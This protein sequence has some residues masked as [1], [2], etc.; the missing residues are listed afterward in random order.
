[1][2]ALGGA[3]KSKC[4][5]RPSAV[6]VLHTKMKRKSVAASGITLAPAG[7]MVPSTCLVSAP[8]PISQ[9]ACSRPGT[10]LV[11]WR[12]SMMA[13]TQHTMT[14]APV[15]QTVSMLRVN[16]PTFFGRGRRP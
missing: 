8:M 9:A 10:P 2:S 11:T 13:T 7:P 16:G 12:R 15:A 3:R 5:P 14:A 1:M 4:A 6:N